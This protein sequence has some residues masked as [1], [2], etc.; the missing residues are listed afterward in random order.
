MPKG[1]E[2]R[3]VRAIFFPQRKCYAF[4]R[5]NMEYLASL[6]SMSRESICSLLDAGL[7]GNLRKIGGSDDVLHSLRP[8]LEGLAN[9][10][11]IQGFQLQ[12]DREALRGQLVAKSREG[13]SAYRAEI[14]VD[15]ANRKLSESLL[16]QATQAHDNVLTAEHMLKE[17][18]QVDHRNYRAHFELGWAYL[19][20]LDAVEH[21]EFHLA[22]A[23]RLAEESGNRAFAVF[24]MR[25]LADACY[26][27]QKYDKAIN[28]A[29]EVI[30]VAPETDHEHLY[31]CARYLA[32]GGEVEAATRRLAAL[33]GKDPA[34]YVQAQAEP[35]FN[36]HESIKRMLHDLRLSR[37]QRIQHYVQTTWQNH[38]L[39]RMLLPDHID[40]NHFF[41]KTFDQHVRVMAQL[42]Y[43]AL[44]D[45]E[46]QI[47][48]LIVHDSERRICREIRQRSIQ[49]ENTTE[50][51]R[52]RWS[53]INK[54]GGMFLHTSAVLLLACLMFFAARYVAGLLGMGALLSADSII[55]YII[56]IVFI[57][58][59]AGGLLIQFVPLGSKKLLRKQIEL[60]NTLKLLDVS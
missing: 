56:S 30:R 28:I 52:Q 44:T 12:K 43:G 15:F 38:R 36:Q 19:F 60:D 32:A 4:H 14:G 46:S 6:K 41:K 54:L 9:R 18:L 33:A 37:V 20:L 50:L 45:R 5:I 22:C 29:L 10:V 23:T 3:Q 42:P 27:Q 55:N 51:R 31:E 11:N 40:S 13:F 34:Y 58:L 17:A 59:I 8:Q 39:S 57:L 24:A 25:H 1:L 16:L 7:Q 2:A 47:G 53:W 35:D 49:Y 21:A 26:T 48:D